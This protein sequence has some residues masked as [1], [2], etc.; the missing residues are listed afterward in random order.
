M[1]LSKDRLRSDVRGKPGG[2]LKLVHREDLPQG[3]AIH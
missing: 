2:E 1:P 3:F